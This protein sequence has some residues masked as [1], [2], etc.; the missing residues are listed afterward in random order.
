[1]LAYGTFETRRPALNTFGS[2]REPEVIGAAQNDAIGPKTDFT[3]V[4]FRQ[5]PHEPTRTRE[6]GLGQVLHRNLQSIVGKIEIP[7]VALPICGG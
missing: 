7:L 5:S 6:Q 3:V 4:A 2:R 1:M